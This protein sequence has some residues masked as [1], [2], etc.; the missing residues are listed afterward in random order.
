M[1]LGEK[2][3][4]LNYT[5][6]TEEVKIKVREVKEHFAQLIDEVE[7]FKSNDPRI[8]ARV[9]TYLEDACMNYVKLLTTS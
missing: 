5:P 7:E 3:V 9:Q 8:A 6:I 1:S 2:R 4:V